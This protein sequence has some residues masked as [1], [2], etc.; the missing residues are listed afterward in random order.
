M[1]THRPRVRAWFEAGARA[2]SEVY[3][4]RKDVRNEEELIYRTTFERET[5]TQT[6]KRHDMLEWTMGIGHTGM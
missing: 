2:T 5:V 1:A 3:F 4:W 6:S